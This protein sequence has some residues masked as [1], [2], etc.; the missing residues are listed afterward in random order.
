MLSFEST[1]SFI[2]TARISLLCVSISLL[3]LSDVPQHSD[4]HFIS[5]MSILSL[6]PPCPH[7]GS[8]SLVCPPMH[9]GRKV[10]S[11]RQSQFQST[12]L[13]FHPS[14][15]S[16]LPP[17]STSVPFTFEPLLPLHGQHRA[18]TGSRKHQFWEPVLDPPGLLSGITVVLVSPR[19]PST[20]GAVSRA[21]S[22]FE[23]DDVRIVQPRCNY[24]TRYV[25][26]TMLAGYA[27]LLVHFHASSEVF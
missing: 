3:S 23:V 10:S 4:W 8:S 15:H 9:H 25:G 18:V 11:S 24:I 13:L 6:L 14:C 1:C 20:V 2:H 17:P 22:C 7:A 21:C 27:G 16:P 19:R 26:H 5:S 12:L